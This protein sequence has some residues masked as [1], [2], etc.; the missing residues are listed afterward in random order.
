M[1]SIEV[2]S[3]HAAAGRLERFAGAC[4]MWGDLFNRPDCGFVQSGN[5]REANN[6]RHSPLCGAICLIALIAALSDQETSARRTTRATTPVDAIA[7]RSKSEQRHWY[8]YK[9]TKNTKR[10]IVSNSISLRVLRFFAVCVNLRCFDLEHFSC[11]LFQQLRAGHRRHAR[12][13]H[14]RVEFDDVRADDVG[15]EPM[16]HVQ[17]LSG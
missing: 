3:I 1:G 16:D 8:R 4:K 17:R 5:K 15:L 13:I 7:N 14:S 6:S 2:R 10:R 12:R 9:T 11:D